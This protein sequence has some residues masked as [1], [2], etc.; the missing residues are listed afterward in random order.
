VRTEELALAAGVEAEVRTAVERRGWAGAGLS[1]EE[2]VRLS[3]FTR[4]REAGAARLVSGIS[5]GKVILAISRRRDSVAEMGIFK[6]SSHSIDSAMAQA[7]VE[8]RE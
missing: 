6:A 5:Q 2:T 3:E 1:R 7:A 8:K 4:G